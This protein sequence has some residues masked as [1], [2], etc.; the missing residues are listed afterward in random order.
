MAWQSRPTDL[1]LY[2]AIAILREYIDK[3]KQ[4]ISGYSV[5]N[6][7][8]SVDTKVNLTVEILLPRTYALAAKIWGQDASKVVSLP[9]T[10]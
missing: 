2:T 3:R 6:L 5:N 10:G 1:T 8:K 4:Y 7:P 9:A